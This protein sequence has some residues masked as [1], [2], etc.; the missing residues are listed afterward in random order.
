MN[1]NQESVDDFIKFIENGINDEWLWSQ[2]FKSWLPSDDAHNQQKYDELRHYFL[3]R[4]TGRFV[5]IN[6][7]TTDFLK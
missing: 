5:F 3:E 1:Y 4:I 7:S 2:Y 6:K